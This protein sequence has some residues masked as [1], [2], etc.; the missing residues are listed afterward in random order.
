VA[1]SNI[2]GK[3]IFHDYENEF[4]SSASLDKRMS[5]NNTDDSIE[6]EVN[7]IKLDTYV[8]NNNISH[9]DLIKIDV[10]L[11]EPEVIEG[12]YNI[13]KDFRPFLLIEVLLPDVAEKHK[14]PF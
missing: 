9:I 11:H 12:M 13:L 7:T 6:Y 4:Q 10:E 1:V 14:H 8:K 2:N 5:R 3:L